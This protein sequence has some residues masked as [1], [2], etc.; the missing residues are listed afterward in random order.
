MVSTAHMN[1][2]QKAN[3]V[4]TVLAHKA[5]PIVTQDGNIRQ[6]FQLPTHSSKKQRMLSFRFKIRELFSKTPVEVVHFGGV[7]FATSPQQGKGQ[8]WYLS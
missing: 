4:V 3:S 1:S 6:R 5:V 2:L 8:P 7:P